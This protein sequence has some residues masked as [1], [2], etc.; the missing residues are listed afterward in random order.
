MKTIV[1]VFTSCDETIDRSPY[2]LAVEEFGLKDSDVVMDNESVGFHPDYLKDAI[3]YEIAEH[4]SGRVQLD[5]DGDPMPENGE[6]YYL[7][8][9][10]EDDVYDGY[11]GE[12]SGCRITVKCR[13]FAESVHRWRPDG[14]T[15]GYD[16][17]VNADCEVPVT[18]EWRTGPDDTRWAVCHIAFCEA[19]LVDWEAL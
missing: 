14:V 13:G 9:Q 2:R 8:P 4:F 15:E 6:A 1:Q 11:D 16:H 7:V 5:E 17:G 12:P 10:S 19:E 18:I 3:T